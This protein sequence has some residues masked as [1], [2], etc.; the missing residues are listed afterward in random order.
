MTSYRYLGYGVTDSNG[1][2][3]LDHD[4]QGNPINGYTGTGAGEVDV[5]ASTDNP[6][7]SGSIVSGTLSVHDCMLYDK[8]ILNDSD[9][10]NLFNNMT[11]FTRESDGTTVSYNNTGSSQTQIYLNVRPQITDSDQM[12]EFK[13]L[14]NT[15]CKVQIGVYNGGNVGE[16]IPFYFTDTGL[17]QIRTS[18]DG[19]V[20]FYL[21]GEE[22]YSQNH[23]KTKEIAFFFQ[24]LGNTLTEFK[25]VDL[26]FYPV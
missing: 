16:Y 5:L 11:A 20:K 17:M 6:I 7:S 3:H 4:P 18:K 25:Y 9:T 19:Y 1:V 8:G 26:Q 14:S 13:V 22:I 24:F 15:F 21:D 23:S 2:A 10:R 12:V